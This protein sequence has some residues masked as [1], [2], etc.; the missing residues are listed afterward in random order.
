MFIN[1]IKKI[2]KIIRFS[3]AEKGCL[4]C[5]LLHNTHTLGGDAREWA[6]PM[7]KLFLYITCI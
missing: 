5:V 1:K 6:I 3:V 7:Q 4:Y 2:K